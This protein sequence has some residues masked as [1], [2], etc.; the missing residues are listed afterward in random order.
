MLLVRSRH[1][2]LSRMSATTPSSGLRPTF[3]RL[4][5]AS[6]SPRRRSLLTEAGIQHVATHPGFDDS[7]LVPTGVSAAEWVTALAHLKAAAG[8]ELAKHSD[9]PRLVLGADTT[10]V[11]GNAFL[12]TP[13]TREEAERMLRSLVQAQHIVVTGVAIIDS[14]TSRRWLFA[15]S[16]LVRWGAVSDEAIRQYLSTDEWHG[17]AGAYNLRERVDAGW[18]IEFDGDPTTIMGLP[19]RLLTRELP[20]IVSE[21]SNP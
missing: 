17:K 1:D 21:L 6:R 5:L 20:R 7:A 4:L 11:Q 8:V 16:A 14:L 12:G 10:C 13:A 3:P 19:M 15:D 9:S 2:D 18:E